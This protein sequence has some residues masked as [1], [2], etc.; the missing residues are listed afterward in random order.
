MISIILSTYNG[1]KYIKEQ[2]D[3]I[4]NQTY[5]NFE[6]IIVDD[7]SQDTTV[8]ILKNYLNQY[9]NIFLYEN[10]KNIGYVKNF[11]KGVRFSKGD[12]IAF[13][14]QDDYW[15]PEKLE[16]LMN[17]IDEYDVAYCDSELVN[18]NLEPKGKKMSTNHN[19]LSSSNPLNFIIKNCVSGHAMLFKK[20]LLEN[21]FEFPE[22]IPHDWWITFLASNRKGVFFVNK[23]LVKYRI[24]DNNCIGGNGHKKIKKEEKVKRHKNRIQQFLEVSRDKEKKV[25]KRILKSY[26]T[27][28][29]IN[30]FNRICVFLPN[31]LSIFAIPNK[32]II[33]KYFY[34]C[35]MFFKVR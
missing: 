14:D 18:E 9:K 29:L 26:E 32:N 8:K 3:S 25:L 21:N 2:L 33:K 13:S 5:K 27:D 16:I 35:S 31:T 22:L 10:E 6:L 1:E 7:F 28:S 15:Y 23:P 17:R 24:H 4:I 11:E 20:S 12:Y 19:L 34:S 30:R